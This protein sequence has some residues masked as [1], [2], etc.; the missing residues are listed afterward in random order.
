MSLTS[1]APNASLSPS[2][3]RAWIEISPGLLFDAHPVVAL[4]AEGVDRNTGRPH[5]CN[6]KARSPSSRRAWIE[7]LCL[8]FGAAIAHVALLAEG[9]DRNPTAFA[10]LLREA[11]SP[12][13]RRAWIE[14]S[15]TWSRA[16]LSL[17]SPS[18]RR[19]WIEIVRWSWSGG[20]SASPS[21]RRAW[22]EILLETGL[23]SSQP[24]ALLAEGVDRNLIL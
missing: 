17:R 12:S 11:R 23:P 7:M 1:A 20:R 15:R 14:I 19:A 21:S 9:V 16:S 6:V 2:S 13:S 18:S 4:L 5:F 10:D 3:R 24:V 22:I 8:S